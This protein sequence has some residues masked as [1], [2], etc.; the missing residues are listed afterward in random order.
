M[1]KIN[2]I[3]TAKM[4]GR[5]Q[6]SENKDISNKTKNPC[7]AHLSKALLPMESKC[8]QTLNKRI[9]DGDDV[10]EMLLQ[11][12]TNLVMCESEE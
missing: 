1:E 7:F 12:D 8:G 2:Q 6:Y 5:E 10:L 3:S 11:K 4:K 9:K